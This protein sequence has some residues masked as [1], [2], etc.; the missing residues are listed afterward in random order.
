MMSIE[1][2]DDKLLEQRYLTDIYYSYEK[3][4]NHFV[5]HYHNWQKHNF[6]DDLY[7]YH[8]L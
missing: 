5:D 3:L 6:L 1:C 8:K 2:S 7:Q 4:S